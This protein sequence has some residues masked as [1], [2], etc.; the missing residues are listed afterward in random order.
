MWSLIIKL[1]NK[2][3]LEYEGMWCVNIFG[4]MNLQS[5]LFV[6]GKKGCL[7]K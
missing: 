7:G 3:R 6:L 1:W 5:R 4:I 2:Y